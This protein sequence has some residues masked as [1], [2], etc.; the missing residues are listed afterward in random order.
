M[1][2]MNH[3]GNFVSPGAERRSPMEVYDR[4]PPPIR[5]LVAEAPYDYTTENI[6]LK[7]KECGEI[8]THRLMA[9]KMSMHVKLNALAAYGPDHP[10]AQ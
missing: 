4:L 3:G 7:I 2:R 10:Q 9:A 1:S 6:E 5:R 8:E